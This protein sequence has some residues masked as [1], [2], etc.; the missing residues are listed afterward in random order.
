MRIDHLANVHKGKHAAQMLGI[1]VSERHLNVLV[2]QIVERN[3]RK[4]TAMFSQLS[5][6]L[7]PCLSNLKLE[8]SMSVNQ[9]QNI[10]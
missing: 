2:G 7:L 8:E 5:L 9:F 10:Y 1:S 3:Y 6:D 4:H